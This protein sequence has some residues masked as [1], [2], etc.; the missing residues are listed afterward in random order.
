MKAVVMRS[1]GEPEVLKVEDVPEPTPAPGEV[2]IKVGAALVN[3]LD[4]Y[5]RLGEIEPNL[6]F[7][8][9]LGLD[10]VGEVVGLGEGATKF[11]IGDR[12][13]AM[14]GYP[15]DK[16]E[17]NVR[18]TSTAKS[19]SFRG[20]QLQGSY[21]QFVVVPEEFVLLDTTGLPPECIGALPV[22]LLASIRAVQISGE[23]KEKDYVLIHA[24]GS[25][26]GITS[27]QVARCLGARIAATVRSDSATE[28]ALRAGA[29]ITIN[30]RTSNF[31]QKVMSWTNGRGVDVAIDSLGGE[32]FGATID[33]VKMQGI[34]V[35][36]GF[37]SGPEV[38]FDIRKF[39]FGQ[40]QIRGCLNADIE[41]F[42]AWLNPIR[43]GKIRPILDS[44]LPL[45]EAAEAHRRVA[46]NTAKGSVVLM[47]WA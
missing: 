24:G 22:P 4:H 13:I 42:A 12:V 20:L 18:P 7:P 19:Y 30:T 29:E 41:D 10:A 37:M 14:P 9:I 21:A 43:Q 26:T 1:F 31:V 25:A 34:V 28:L 36:M 3:R 33:A 16:N 32:G 45:S 35:S 40:K 44:V 23:V 27:I 11:K 47:P 17:F 6:P 15:T 2:L 39:F 38:N 5:I 8:H 46:S